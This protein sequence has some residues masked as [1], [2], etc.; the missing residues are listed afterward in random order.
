MND[1]KHYN[2]Y[3]LEWKNL[4][5]FAML[6]IIIS[7]KNSSSEKPVNYWITR[8]Q[9]VEEGYYYSK[10]VF[11]YQ[12]N[13]YRPIVSAEYINDSLVSVL[14]FKSEGKMN[15]SRADLDADTLLFQLLNTPRNRIIEISKTQLVDNGKPY[16]ITELM[17]DSIYSL[18]KDTLFLYSI[19]HLNKFHEV[20]SPS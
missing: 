1:L 6:I 11:T 12:S 2:W 15:Y 19:N 14:V 7:C 5:V 18:Q 17:H 10:D 4:M 3:S 16:Q 9:K 20:I 8:Y 13:V